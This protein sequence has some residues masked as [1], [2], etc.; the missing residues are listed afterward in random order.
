LGFPPAGWLYLGAHH[1]TARI[2]RTERRR[3]AA[4]VPATF[5][6]GVSA[7]ALAPFLPL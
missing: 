3:R 1:V 6:T 7:F 4:V 2:A 5:A